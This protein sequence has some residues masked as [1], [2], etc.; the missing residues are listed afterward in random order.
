M[1]V[2]MTV[3]KINGKIYIGQDRYNNVLYLGSGLLLKQAFIKY[4]KHNFE[5]I[6]IERCLNK[7]HLNEREKY[8]ILFYNSKDKNIGY[9]ITDGGT[10]GDTFSENPNKEITREKLRAA[11]KKAMS[12]P[13]IKE[14]ISSSLKKAMSNPLIKEKISSSL[15]KTFANPLC[16]EKLSKSMKKVK[17]TKEWNAKVGKNNII[18]YHGKKINYFISTGISLTGIANYFNIPE[19]KLKNIKT[20]EKEPDVELLLKC[21]ELYDAGKSMSRIRLLVENAPALEQIKTFINLS[22]LK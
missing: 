10:G 14:K 15:K 17:H 1:I 16:R 7:E 8:W 21:K 12:N 6:I 11:S 13:L 18:R 5:K 19:D 2:Y 20:F 22:K 4:G 3:N 9:N